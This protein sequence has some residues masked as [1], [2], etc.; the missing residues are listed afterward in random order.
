MDN[1]KTRTEDGYFIGF[2]GRE[3]LD[4]NELTGD[5]DELQDTIIQNRH[6]LDGMDGMKST[7]AG[8]RLGKKGKH[9]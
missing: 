9:K 4:Q 8:R 7:K 1:N 3:F 2:D 5:L 6:M